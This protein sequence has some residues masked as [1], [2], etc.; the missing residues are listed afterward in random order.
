MPL[1]P[2]DVANV[3]FSTPPI[4][5]R[6][7]HED[8]VDAF[9]DL[10]QAELARL[11]QENTDLRNQIAQRD[12]QR[13]AGPVD[14]GG[15][16]RPVGPPGPVM[17]SIRPPMTEQTSPGGDHNVHAAK[18]LGLAQEMADRLTGDANAEADAMLSQARATS[19][20]LLSEA[21]DKAEGMVTEARIR[22]ETMLN[23][24]RAKAEILDRQSREKAASLERDAARKHTEI[25]GSISQEKTILEKKI[26]EL[27]TFEHEY[28]TR[29]KTYLQSQLRELDGPGSAAPAD[30]MRTQQDFVTSGSGARAETRS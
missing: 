30:P 7:Y 22:A 16:L 8:E 24:A 5:K 19:E 17:V 12:A 23:D 25:L 2:A 21:R 11:I 6:G 3:S 26:D 10:V 18:V 9:L 27:R 28:R 13:R 1:M 20:R 14:T 15:D 4:G 29:L